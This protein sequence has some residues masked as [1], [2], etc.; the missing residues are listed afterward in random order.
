MRSF[1]VRHTFP[2]RLILEPFASLPSARD[3]ADTIVTA[4]EMN[5]AEVTIKL[6]DV[7]KFHKA[8]VVCVCLR[9][10]QLYL[11]LLS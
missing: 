6:A 11:S 7:R 10:R 5:V 8:F 3:A 2:N 9:L 4:G 1:D